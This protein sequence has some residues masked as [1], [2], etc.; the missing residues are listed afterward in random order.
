MTAGDVSPFDSLLAN[1][2]TEIT[3]RHP[4]YF[5][6][7]TLDVPS[8]DVLQKEYGGY[9]LFSACSRNEIIAVVSAGLTYFGEH[10]VPVRSNVAQT[11]QISS[12]L[13]RSIF[14]ARSAERGDLPLKA[15]PSG[16]LTFAEVLC[17]RYSLER[18]P[19]GVC[20]VLAKGSGNPLL[21]V[22]AIGLPS[23]LW[24]RLL[25]DPSLDRRC[26]IVQDPGGLLFEGGVPHSASLWQDVQSIR[27][28]LLTE[29]MSK[30]DVL[31]WCSG[32]RVAVELA[33]AMPERVASL[34]LVAPTFHGSAEVEKYASPFEDTLPNIHKMLIQDPPRGR[35]F[36][37][38]MAQSAP[39][40]DL[41]ALKYEPEKCVKAV[42]S[43]PPHAFAKDLTVPFSAVEDFKN[44]MKRA[45]T[46]KSYDVG[47]ALA[48]IRCSITLVTGTHDGL[49]NTHAARDL[50]ARHAKD[51][52]HITILGAGHH[53]HLL[54]YGYFKYILDC[55]LAHITPL[56]T[57]RLRISRLAQPTTVLSPAQFA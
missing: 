18:T 54:Q 3:G 31:A 16:E 51:V 56:K 46:D 13:L 27:D 25:N 57:F 34:M 23:K 14:D 19:S 26:L 22:S 20:Y 43:L 30:V 36:L 21:I 8:F 33:R 35:S 32:A 48:G 44:Y 7:R 12:M 15:T 37:Q 41:S 53:I 9:P 4:E 49:T 47:G 29:G 10:G 50:L 52:A 5:S 28:V 40:W 2:L 1:A 45:D 55:A 11:D 17:G 6:H 24:L 42:L 39:M 38:S